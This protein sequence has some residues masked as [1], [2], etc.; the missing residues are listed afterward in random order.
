MH[1]DRQASR[2]GP[3][4]TEELGRDALRVLCDRQS[5]VIDELT[6]QIATLRAAADGIELRA[7]VRLAIDPAAPAA[8]R[9]AIT[10]LLRGEA[11]PAMLA[12]A[13]LVASELVTNSVRHS[14]APP[15]AALVLRVELAL[16]TLWLEVE[17]PGQ[18]G[19]VAPRAPDLDGGGGMGLNL[20]R[21]I[22]ER[23]GV[24]QVGAGG[25]RVWAR[26]PRAA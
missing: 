15:D 23:W 2:D 11:A 9:A 1:V 26:L 4:A 24:E 22:S 25:T 3:S 16:T 13:Q 8:A 21:T 20:V 5:V 17:D 12:S 10:R 18:G 6:E 19:S 7:E 14:G